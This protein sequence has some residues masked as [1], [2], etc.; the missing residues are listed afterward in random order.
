MFREHTTNAPSEL[1]RVSSIKGGLVQSNRARKEERWNSATC[2][3]LQ[4][5]VVAVA[6]GEGEHCSTFRSDEVG[7]GTSCGAEQRQGH[8]A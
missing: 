1:A 8:A 5:P 2:E 6:A 4:G 3:G 7:D